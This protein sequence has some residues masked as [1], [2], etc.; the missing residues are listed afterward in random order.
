MKT[1]TIVVLMV[2]VTWLKAQDVIITVTGVSGDTP[3]ELDTVMIDN[4]SNGTNL[5][6]DDF[7]AGVTDYEINLSQ[8]IY[9]SVYDIHQRKEY[10]ELISNNLYK[11]QILVGLQNRQTIFVQIFDLSGRVLAN[12]NIKGGH[13]NNL[14][15]ITTNQ[16]SLI[17]IST[18]LM[19]TTFKTVGCFSGKPV[20]IK[21]KEA[22]YKEKGGMIPVKTVLDDFIFNLGDSLKITAINNNLHSNFLVKTP[23]NLDHYHIYLS[24]PCLGAETLTDF[25]GNV[26]NT[27]V[28]GNQCWMKENLRAI[29][30]A[31]GSPLVDGTGIPTIDI[32]TKYWFNYDDDPAIAEVYGKLYAWAAVM[33]GE[34]S[35]NSVP[36]GVQGV[37]PDG[38]HV[39]SKAEWDILVSYLGGENI[40]GGKL[41]ESGYGH[42]VYPNTGANNQSGFSALP[43]G[44]LYL[45]YY[46]GLYSTSYIWSSTIY[47]P[48]ASC[49]WSIRLYNYTNIISINGYQ[50]IQQKGKSIRC[51]K[52]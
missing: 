33:N 38:W 40:A 9:N 12:S 52:D 45:N 36:S 8:G 42:W 17:K 41:K 46:G 44:G 10:I 19:A 15:E 21:N 29:H 4:L 11:T 26:Y 47:P 16:F 23:Q 1:I 30:F 3:V 31:D 6:L 34:A 25:D 37:C 7:P 20:S 39:P 28:I 22:H 5:V 48:D 14:I 27:V 43:G 51:I 35:S 13:G 18:N 49:T 32:T 24:S 2:F 50:E